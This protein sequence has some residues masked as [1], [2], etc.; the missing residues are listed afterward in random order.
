VLHVRLDILVIETATDET[1]GIE[2]GVDGVHGDL[3]LGGIT[4]ETLRVGEGDVG[5]GGAVTLV[6]G[7]NLDTVV[8]PD[9]NARVGSTE[10]DTDGYWRAIEGADRDEWIG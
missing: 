4:D 2:D 9:G 7:D 1:L 10:I 8:L 5:G 3:V 6:V